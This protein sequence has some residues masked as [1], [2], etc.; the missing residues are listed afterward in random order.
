MLQYNLVAGGG[1]IRGPLDGA[2]R[3]LL[4]RD[5]AGGKL[6]REGGSVYSPRPAGKVRGQLSA[7]LLA[8]AVGRASPRR[9]SRGIFRGSLLG[10][11]ALLHWRCGAGLAVV[12]G[13]GL[14][15]PDTRLLFAAVRCGTRHDDSPRQKASHFARLI[16]AVISHFASGV[17]SRTPALY[18]S[19]GR[20][21]TA[22]VRRSLRGR[23]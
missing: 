11:E 19:G 18:T 10:P 16:Y 21:R 15:T 14:R 13:V 7:P 9:C 8:A 12:I 17:R 20:W 23:S 5:D 3:H 2:G 4:L 1:G 6:G 22:P